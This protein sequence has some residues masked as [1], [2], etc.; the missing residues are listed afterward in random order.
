MKY[1]LIFSV[2]VIAGIF[3]ERSVRRNYLDESSLMQAR[4]HI[5]FI[6][7]GGC[8]YFAYKL[9]QRLDKNRYRIVDVDTMRHIL[10]EDQE[11]GLYLDSEGYH[12]KMEI[13]LRYGKGQNRIAEISEDSLRTL[14]YHARWNERFD[15]RD[16]ILIN[17]FIKSL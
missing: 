2:G 7:A 14:I 15:K 5:K 1:L 16:T 8:G 6:N 11:N 9:Y 17:D 13:Q 3:A 10:L 4:D 12:T